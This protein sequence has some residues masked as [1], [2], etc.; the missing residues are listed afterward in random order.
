MVE[1]ATLVGASVE[2]A[3]GVESERDTARKLSL[4]REKAHGAYYWIRVVRA[5][6]ADSVEWIALQ[7]ESKELARALDDLI[8][9]DQDQEP[10]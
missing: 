1:A 7:Q 6:I 9:A 5:S 10:D 4:A 8:N 3:N 2:E